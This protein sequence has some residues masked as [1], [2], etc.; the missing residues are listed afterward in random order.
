MSCLFAEGLEQTE[1]VI[2]RWRNV[3]TFGVPVLCFLIAVLESE[4]AAT[5]EVAT[6]INAIQLNHSL[7]VL[8]SVVIFT[9]SDASLNA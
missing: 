6:R 4:E 5:T 7:R 1:F 8:Q 2:L 3:Q 9:Q